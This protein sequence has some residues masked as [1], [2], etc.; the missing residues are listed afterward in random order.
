MSF[1]PLVWTLHGLIPVL[2]FFFCLPGI[3]ILSMLSVPILALVVGVLTY[4]GHGNSA[5]LTFIG[6]FCLVG[7]IWLVFLTLA[8]IRFLRDRP[9][10]QKPKE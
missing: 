10:D 8:A 2:V 4:M 1:T 6:S 9:E 5:N 7:L 3:N